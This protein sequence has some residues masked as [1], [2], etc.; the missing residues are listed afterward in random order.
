MAR[1]EVFD[2]PMC[3]STGVCGPSVDPKL[4][5]FAADLD[6]LRRRGVAVDRF[7]LSQRPDAFARNAAVMQ[8]VSD[9]ALPALAVDGRVVH[10]GS[11]PTRAQLGRLA[12][13]PLEDGA[14][15]PVTAGKLEECRAA[16]SDGKLLF[17]AVA[18]SAGDTALAV[19]GALEFQGSADL[20]PS[21][22]VEFGPEDADGRALLREL[23]AP[24]PP[25]GSVVLFLAPPGGIIAR[26]T[27]S[28]TK[29]DL[30]KALV[31]ASSCSPRSG[32]C[33]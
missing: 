14:G 10:T 16:L 25:G 29:R 32:C 8:I 1:L 30:V 18:G 2:P 22:V 13:V 15:A 3:C 33:G 12:G 31:A 9:G 24:P 27:G 19:R 11:Y 28:P 6:W 20:P 5:R 21:A 23:G 17:I 26:F 4:A 7:T